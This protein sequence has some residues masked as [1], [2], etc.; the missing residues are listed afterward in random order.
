MPE[1]KYRQRIDGDASVPDRV[2]TDRELDAWPAPDTATGFFKR[3]VRLAQL[4][5]PDRAAKDLEEAALLAPD[6]PEVQYNLGTAYLSLG[7]FEQAL[8]NL[9]RS[10][11]LR[12]GSADAYGNRA[13]AF[14]AMGDVVQSRRDVK[15]ATELGADRARLV[16]VA[17]VQGVALAPASAHSSATVRNRCTDGVPTTNG[18]GEPGRRIASA[19][20]F[21]GV[22]S[23]FG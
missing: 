13:V 22:R 5:F 4:G 18:C 7:M 20:L 17:S 10:I 1:E 8:R 3:G 9:D 23:Y 6:D 21:C 15:R 19:G 11:S 16:S 2:P 12:P 14:A